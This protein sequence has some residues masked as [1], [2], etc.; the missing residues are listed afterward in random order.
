M[1]QKL[2]SEKDVTVHHA[3]D[4]PHDAERTAKGDLD[5]PIGGGGYICNARE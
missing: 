2:A 3:T 4:A 5:H 1:W